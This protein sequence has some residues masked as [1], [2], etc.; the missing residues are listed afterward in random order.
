MEPKRY[1]VVGTGGR[2]TGMF[3][4]PLATDFPRTAR[5]AAVCD[6]NPVRAA[7][8]VS[9][10]PH[11][12]PF[13][14][15][16]RRMMREV[17]PDGLA[18]AS[19]D[20]TH[21]AY[22]VAGL[23]AGKRVYC[24]KPLCTTAAQCRAILSAAR[25]SKGVCFVTHNMRYGAAPERI[26]A[27]LRAGTIGRVS[28]MQFDE[29]LD[30]CHGADYFRRWHRQLANSG[31]L[32]IHKASH[33]FDLLNWWAGAKPAEVR[34]QGRLA[35]YG[36]NG[37]F[38]HR[39]CRGCPHARRC[40]F[41]ADLF[42]IETYR[43]MYLRAEGEDGYLRDGCVFDRGI[44]ICDQMSALIRYEN[45]IEAAYTLTAF[46]PYESMRC[47]FEGDRGRL[48]YVV[49]YNTGWTRSGQRLPGVEEHAGESLRL[50]LPGKGIR[51][52]TIPARK[53]GH[54][55]ADPRLRAEFFGRD[56]SAG[57]S[58]NMAS[59]EEAVQAVLIGAAANRSIAAGKPVNVQRLLCS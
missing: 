18:I 48:E 4:L 24:E 52:V 35:F 46:S 58:E 54:G 44:D 11:P 28:F 39:R 51:D 7:Y 45:G 12:V 41:H 42:T 30:R 27:I 20:C 47:A 31:G 33:H 13:Y 17:D 53:G 2:G 59:L 6:V 49:R 50:F 36:R 29:T 22:V 9:R 34:A 40:A 19:R 1:A 10:L 55:G 57:R 56:W 8:C 43:E 25:R 37:P 38:R 15:S 3:A 16:F 21:A 23:K 14:T 32:L 5:L 26:R